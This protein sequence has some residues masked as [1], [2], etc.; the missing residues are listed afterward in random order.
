M[1]YDMRI[2][3]LKPGSVPQYMEAVREVAFKIRQDHGVK[4]AGL[5][6]HGHRETEQGGP[7]LGLR[8]PGAL[9]QGANGRDQR[10]EMGTGLCIPRPGPDS[11]AA[12]H[13]HERR[14]LLRRASVGLDAVR[15]INA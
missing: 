5:V 4:L 8:R 6:L 10:S 11:Q 3:D 7:H 14:G 1:I 12:G 2:Y 9:R 15:T 13:D